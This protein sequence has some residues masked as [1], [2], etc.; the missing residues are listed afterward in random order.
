MSGWRCQM[1]FCGGLEFLQWPVYTVWFWKLNRHFYSSYCWPRFCSPNQTLTDPHLQQLHWHDVWLL[2]LGLSSLPFAVCVEGR[3]QST[4]ICSH[5]HELKRALSI[6]L[7]YSLNNV[8]FIKNS[9][10]HPVS[11]SSLVR[12]CWLADYILLGAKL[13]VSGG[14]ES[15]SF[16]R[17][18]RLSCWI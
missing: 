18:R 9:S 10:K 7:N 14:F 5:L 3:G 8:K 15:N 12:V 6:P 13:P 1:G 11:S 16:R 17:N 2:R 4:L